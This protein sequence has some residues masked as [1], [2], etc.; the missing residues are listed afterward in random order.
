MVISGPTTPV[1]ISN[2]KSLI[3]ENHDAVS[4]IWCYHQSCHRAGRTPMK[5]TRLLAWPWK[6]ENCRCH[7]TGAY[8]CCSQ[9]RQWS[10]V[11]HTAR[12]RLVSVLTSPQQQ[13]NPLMHVDECR[14][15]VLYAFLVLSLF[16]TSC[17]SLFSLPPPLM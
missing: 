4:V 15:R 8:S 1:E 13:Q 12:P 5:K 2:A 6:C 11:S 10:R 17:F 7:R 9:G 14:R 3:V 16:L